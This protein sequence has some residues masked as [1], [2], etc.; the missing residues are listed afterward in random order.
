VF[1]PY[2]VV[3]QPAGRVEGQVMVKA[4]NSTNWGFMSIH[5][6]TFKGDLSALTKP[7]ST[8]A[9]AVYQ[10]QQGKTLFASFDVLAQALALHNKPVA[11]D[12]NVFAQLLLAALNQVN[13]EPVRARAGKVVPVVVTF[14]NTGNQ[15][16]TGQA[17]LLLSANLGMIQSAEFALVPETTTWAMPFNLPATGHTSKTL[18]VRLPASGSAAIQLQLQTSPD[19]TTRFEKALTL[20]TQ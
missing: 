17:L 5:N 6:R 7:K 13:P 10:Y 20:S 8:N 18:Y 14:E 9:I 16:A 3:E 12:A 2:A 4:W 15:S 1:A 11:A 19:G